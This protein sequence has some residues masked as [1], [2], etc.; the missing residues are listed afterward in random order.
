MTYKLHGCKLH[1]SIL[2]ASFYKLSNAGFH[3]IVATTASTHVDTVSTCAASAAS[4]GVLCVLAH[5]H[6]R[7][8]SPGARVVAKE[9]HRRKHVCVLL[10]NTGGMQ[11]S[12]SFYD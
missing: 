3:V 7:F 8:T 9:T 5:L 10:R 1:I 4:R 6:G 12:R 11:P 2:M